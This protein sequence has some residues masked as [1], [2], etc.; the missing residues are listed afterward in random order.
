MTRRKRRTT[1]GRRREAG[2]STRV[3]Q[4]PWCTVRN[5]YPPF[6]IASTDEIE[7]IHES[8]L[9]VLEEIGVNFLLDEGCVILKSA[10]VDVEEENPRVR[11]DRHFIEEQ[12]AKAP[13]EWTLH[14]RNP[15]HNRIFGGS[16]SNFLPVGGNPNISDIEGAGATASWDS[17][18]AGCVHRSTQG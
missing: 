2:A 7:S 8:A 16:Y 15:A 6:E 12:V 9:E 13:A 3:P 1:A 17:R 18:R 11:L 14:A 4:L 5:P 10:G